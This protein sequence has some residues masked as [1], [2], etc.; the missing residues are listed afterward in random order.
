MQNS[1]CH[2]AGHS[3]IDQIRSWVLRGFVGGLL[4]VFLLAMPSLVTAAEDQKRVLAIYGDRSDLAAS[5]SAEREIQSTMTQALGTSLDFHSEYIEARRIPEDES[6]KA[7]RDLVHQK[8]DQEKFDVVIAVSGLAVRFVQAYGNELFPGVP[9]VAYGNEFEVAQWTK[10]PPAV[11]GVWGKL[12]L[13]GTLNL[14]LKLQ[15]DTRQI[16]LVTGSNKSFTDSALAQITDYQDRLSFTTLDSRNL[17]RLLSEVSQLSRGTVILFL[18]PRQDEPGQGALHSDVL[19]QIIQKA[20]VPVYGMSASDLGAGIVG[21]ALFDQEAMARETA[22]L[23]LRVLRGERVQ[24]IPA[25]QS[26]SILPMV[27]WRQL[28]HWGIKESSLPNQAIIKFREPTFWEQYKWRIAGLL[29]LVVLQ[30]FLIA[31]LLFERSRRWRATRH[32]AQSEERYRNVVETQTELICRYLADTTLIFVNDAYCRY[33]GKSREELIGTK[34]LELTPVP[35]RP[36]VQQHV[37]SLVDNPRTEIHEHEVICP[38]G[39]TGW[40]QWVNRVISHGDDRIEL[41]GI[42]RDITER[43]RAENALRETEERNRAILRAVPDLMFLQTEDG[44]Y[45]DYHAKDQRALMVPPEQFLGKNM[46]EFML[47]ELATTFRQAFKRAFETGETQIQEYDLQ[48]NG[49]REWFEARIARCNGSKILSVVRDITE[50]KRALEALSDSEEFN[51]QIVESIT[52]CIKILDLDGRIVYMSQNGRRLLEIDN[53]EPYLNTSWIDMWTGEGLALARECVAKARDGE[54]ADFHG[55][56]ATVKGTPKWWYTTISPIR[57][58]RGNV[59]NLLAVSRDITEQKQARAA[60]LESEVRFAKA[61]KANPQ[62]MSLTTMAEGMY[63]D[64]NQAFLSMSGYSRGEVIGHTSSELKVFETAAHRKSLLLDPLLS[65]GA[66]R[67]SEMKFRIKDGSFRVLLSSAELLELGGEKCILVTSSDITERKKLEEELRLSEREFSTL[68]ENSP[69][70][71]SRLDRNLRYIYMSP[72]LARISGQPKSRFI[73][74]TQ[75]EAALPGYDWEGF[76]ASCREAFATGKTVHRAFEF[77]GRS[78]WTR[79]IPEFAPDGTV[80]SVMTISED[81]TQRIRVEQELIELT[82]RLFNLQDEER[83][84]IARELHD[85]TAQNLFGISVNLARL[86]QLELGEKEEMD[87]LIIECQSL[88]EQ[89]LQEIRTLSYLLHPPLLDQ[90]GLAPALQWYVEGFSQRSGIY[91]DVIAQP[92]GRLPSDVEMALFRIVQEALTNVRR[93]SGSDTA[94]IRLERHPKEI[95]LEIKDRGRGLPGPKT[96]YPESHVGMGVGIP[97]MRQRLR[98]LGGTLEISSDEKGTTISAVVPLA[99]GAAH[100]ANS[101]R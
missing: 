95:L 76:E 79:V 29:A 58:A 23:A 65:A 35:V 82:V 72:T 32:L 85:G 11:T 25:Q 77:Q 13:R 22:Q 59:E 51:R 67:N 2:L 4:S 43:K 38:D 70:V 55:F 86:G 54:V 101:S 74:K 17:D 96:D 42:G 31:L 12:D 91:V 63:L 88:G 40:Q 24:D 46:S 64:V 45:L 50:R 71:I 18:I 49:E 87:R 56:A 44:V 39:S 98:Q 47:P 16:A 9:V 81:V 93:H 33:F 66:V 8:Y 62:P 20:S 10:G 100:G 53:I 75:K 34:F 80:E 27:D 7:L 14:I 6:F 57:D 5:I 15:P 78:Y 84:R 52:D 30:T 28:Q 90:A 68:V 92:I 83:R 60:V 69:D 48:L 26:T 73:G 61:F 94:S 41:Q 89:S 36:Q 97:G 1:V 19:P 99:N 21:G 37:Q 3:L